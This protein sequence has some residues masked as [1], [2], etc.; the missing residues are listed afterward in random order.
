MSEEPKYG[1]VLREITTADYGLKESREFELETEVLQLRETIRQLT[2]ET[3][4]H[5]AGGFSLG[6]IAK[7]LGFDLGLEV[8]IEDKIRQ[9][10]QNTQR[11]QT[12]QTDRTRILYKVELTGDGDAQGRRFAVAVY[13]RCEADIYLMG[14]D[15]LIVQYQRENVFQLRR[16][17]HKYPQRSE[18]QRT[19][20]W[21]LCPNF[22]AWNVPVCSISYWTLLPEST[23]IVREGYDR[24][25][26]DPMLVT[27]A[28]TGARP[29]RTLSPP[30]EA[31]SLYQIANQLPFKYVLTEDD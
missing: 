4:L 14:T 19:Q 1:E 25:V 11:V 15:E 13:Q 21:Y 20:A 29:A 2:Q 23:A 6:G 31:R 10:E 22:T 16:R 7:N 28:A 9:I 26:E 30:S 3:E 5:R 18:H 24:G 8:S 27:V 17:R 12:T